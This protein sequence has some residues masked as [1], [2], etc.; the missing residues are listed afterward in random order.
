[1]AAAATIKRGISASG[2]SPKARCIANR[3]SAQPAPIVVP[4]K[5]DRVVMEKTSREWR[6]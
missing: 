5:K 3:E 6:E 4:N 1:M 2:D